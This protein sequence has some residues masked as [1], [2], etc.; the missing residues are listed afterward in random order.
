MIVKNWKN[1]T[2]SCFLFIKLLFLKIISSSNLELDTLLYQKQVTIS[3]S[4]H[5]IQHLGINIW[6]SDLIN[7]LLIQQPYH[8]TSLAILQQINGQNYPNLTI[9][10]IMSTNLIRLMVP[11]LGI[12]HVIRQL[13]Q[14]RIRKTIY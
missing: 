6:L 1:H 14:C 5:D 8:P 4:R 2:L 3:H 13:I 7:A 12:H 9:G 11:Y 10:S